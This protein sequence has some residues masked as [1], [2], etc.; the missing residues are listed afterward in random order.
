MLS[1]VSNSEAAKVL[2]SSVLPT[3]VGPRNRKDPTGDHLH[4]LVLA[5]H[6]LVQDV[7]Q[8][9]QFLP[10]ALFQA[11]DRDAGPAGNDLRDFLLGDDLAQQPLPAL[12]GRELLLLGRQAPLQL[13]QL[14]QPQFGG[15]VKAVLALGPFGLLAQLLYFLPQRPVPGAAPGARPPLRVHRIGLGPQPGQV[16]AQLVQPGGTGRVV[17]LDSALSNRDKERAQGQGLGHQR[18]GKAQ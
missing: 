10:F 15:P 7:V 4:G 5:H 14:A 2:A 11:A 12:L 3:P 9:E 16:L 13:G 6:P 17:P 1:S 8:A 18:H